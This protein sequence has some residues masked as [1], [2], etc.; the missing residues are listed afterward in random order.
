MLAMGFEQSRTY[1]DW[2]WANGFDGT[3]EKSRADLQEERD[4]FE[5]IAE[6]RK[7]QTRLHKNPKAFLEAVCLGELT[8]DEIDRPNFKRA[9]AEIEISSESEETR[10]SLL[11]ML[12][13]LNK[14]DDMAF[15][16][17][18][19][20]DETPFVRGLIKLHDR[21]VL[22]LRPLE[23]WK[24]K[25]KNRERRFGE[26]THHLFDKFGDVPRFMESVWL[27]ND[28]ASW[29]YRDWYVHLGRGHNL[30]TAKSPVPLTKKMAHHF[31][32]APDNFTVEQAIRWGQLHALGAGENA[33]H[34]LVATRLGRSF[35]NEGFWFTVLRFI[36]DNPM[37]DPRQI[38][39]VVDYLH[40]QRYE[41]V[42]IEVAPGQWRQE[43]APQPGL[44]MSGRTVETLMR[45]VVAWH[46]SLGRLKGLPG[47]NYEKAEFDGIA[48]DRTPGGKPIRW[49]I[50][51]LRNAKDL[52]LESDELKHCVASYHWS[53]ARGDCT[54][55]SLSV[56]TG[57]G[58]YERRQ[59]IEVDSNRTI[60]QCRGLAN[61]DPKSDE[62]SIVTAWA[63]EANLRISSYF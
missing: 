42:D 34:A 27:R 1:F 54:I 15:Q 30:R 52:Q 47:D 58:A 2:C 16:S 57:G 11:N 25:S 26:L 6:K 46:D 56:S 33:I 29:R 49:I 39:P 13:A 35:E 36:A 38:G 28:R 7:R 12:L 59:T 8:S 5:A 55:W 60:V 22:W 10:L 41:P 40:N 24:P 23:D 62:W 21:R 32:R 20:D 61:R 45:Q 43:P 31:L 17:V 18:T 14:H 50:R 63:R 4:A 19:G 53:C 48:V 44:S 9:A 3:L 51:Q 37:L